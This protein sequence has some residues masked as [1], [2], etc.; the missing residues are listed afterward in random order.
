MAPSPQ[1]HPAQ[2][3]PSPNC[4][5]QTPPPPISIPARRPNTNNSHCS[6]L[7]PI[8]PPRAPVLPDDVPVALSPLP[9]LQR[10]CCARRAP[11]FRPPHR[12]RE[13]AQDSRLPPH[14]TETP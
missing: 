6:S 14:T 11:S 9:S 2:P 7:R 12:L 8:S 1:L 3:L 10:S 5:H 4:P 13:T